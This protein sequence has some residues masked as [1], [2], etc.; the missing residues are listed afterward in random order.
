MKGV[1]SF[2]AGETA[3]VTGGTS[4]IGLAVTRLLLA[5]SVNV[6][7]FHL[8]AGPPA[9]ADLEAAFLV[10]CDI[11]DEGQVR[12][13]VA[14]TVEQFG[15]LHMLANNAALVGLQAEAPLLEH[16]L[17]LFRSVVE[18][19]LTAQFLVLREVALAMVSSETPGRIVNVSS[20]R[21]H[22]GGERIAA[23]SSAKTGL[24]GLT[25]CAALE[26]APHRI[27][28]NAVAP[29]WIESE[30]AIR[31]VTDTPLALFD[32]P[33]P[34]GRGSTSDAARVI[35]ALLSPDSGFVTGSIW[36]VDGGVRTY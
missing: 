21:G 25:R 16:P 8:S 33:I 12:K 24:L 10:P 14:A 30:L 29:G 19:N 3:I 5:N 13:G 34:L 28:V 9:P 6:A 15:G 22:L 1:F 2:A 20:V 36:G 35:A 27:R 11:R 23:Y 32:K 4:G 17:E 7:V 26:L 31:E 18:T